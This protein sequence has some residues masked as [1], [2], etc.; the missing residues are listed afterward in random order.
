[1]FVL[2]KLFQ[3]SLIF[4]GEARSLPLSKASERLFN[5]VGSCLTLKHYTILER[6]ARDEHSSLSGKPFQPRSLPSRGAPERCFTWVTSCHTRKHY[7]ILERLARDEHSSL[8]RKFVTYGRK[9]FYN[10][11]PRDGCCKFFYSRNQCYSASQPTIVI[12]SSS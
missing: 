3:P 1:M 10:I 2:G 9:K 12:I 5:R 11:G 4:L 8:L 7:T 6:L